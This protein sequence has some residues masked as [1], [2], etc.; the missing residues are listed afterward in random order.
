MSKK[1]FVKYLCTFLMLLIIT[2][3]RKEYENNVNVLAI[4][5]QANMIS[6]PDV[7]AERSIDAAWGLENWGRIKQLEFDCLVTYY[8]SD[9]SFYLTE[10]HYDIYPWSNSIQISGS[11]PQGDY[12]WQLHNGQFD[13]LKGNYKIPTLANK[14]FADA[15]LSIISVPASFLDN[16][17][18]FTRGSAPIY[19]RGQLFYPIIRQSENIEENSVLMP[20]T[21][22]Y[23]DENNSLVDMIWF[24]CQNED[25]FFMVRGYD[26]IKIKNG[27][28]LIPSR[29]EIFKTDDKGLSQIK[30]V[31]IDVNS[32]KN[33]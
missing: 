6:V 8:Q 20:N 30:L 15:V 23:Q 12:T 2:G 21:V 19:L 1:Y 31:K 22:F 25:S 7:Y 27:E 9:V 3:C 24:A 4:E 28:V 11:E 32:A 33:I 29:I 18:Y 26:Y 5:P 13:I 17:V 16:S 10:Q 14:C